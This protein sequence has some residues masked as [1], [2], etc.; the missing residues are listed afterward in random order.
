MTNGILWSAKLAN[1]L[2]GVPCV[3]DDAAIARH[4]TQR[5]NGGKLFNRGAPR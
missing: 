4:L 1:P 3:L 5:L 2:G